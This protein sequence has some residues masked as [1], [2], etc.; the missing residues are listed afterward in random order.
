MDDMQAIAL[1]IEDIPDLHDG[2]DLFGM[3]GG[4][5]LNISVTDVV[6]GVVLFA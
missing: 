6:I 1:T 5:V 3:G 2:D 4:D